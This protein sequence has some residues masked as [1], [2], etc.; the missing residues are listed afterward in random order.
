MKY[1]LLLVFLSFGVFSTSCAQKKAVP[2]AVQ[3]AFKTKFPTVKKVKWDQEGAE[4]WE[5]EFK[6]NKK[7]MSA[8]YNLDGTLIEIE[9][10]MKAGDLP[11]A[12]KDAVATQFAG[13]E[14]EEAALVETPQTSTAYEVELK[15]GKDVIEALFHA[16]GTLLQQKTESE[17]DEDED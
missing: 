8:N 9:T 15:K 11:Q 10:E 7:E 17:D 14:M 12:V 1:F 5:A 13:Y 6:M 3:Q 16:D 2:A 4:E